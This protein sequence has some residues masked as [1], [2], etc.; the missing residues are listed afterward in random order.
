MGVKRVGNEIGAES[1]DQFWES[2]LP[3]TAETFVTR[4]GEIGAESRDHLGDDEHS[5]NTSTIV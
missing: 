4:F 1:R 5:D 2:A 3:A